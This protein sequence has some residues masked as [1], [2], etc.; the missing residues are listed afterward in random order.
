[1]HDLLVLSPISSLSV[2]E[3]ESNIEMSNCDNN[4]ANVNMD[5]APPFE[6]VFENTRHNFFENSTKIHPNL[7]CTQSEALM[8]IMMYYLKHNLS[9]LV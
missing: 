5:E 3:N 9:W 4:S 2:S 6:N 8:M 1:M 7:E